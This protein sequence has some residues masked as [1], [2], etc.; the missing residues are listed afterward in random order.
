MPARIIA[1][2]ELTGRCWLRL[3]TNVVGSTDCPCSFGTS[4]VSKK[5]VVD[6]AAAAK[7]ARQ[8]KDVFMR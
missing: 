8:G 4:V 5:A 1:T 7:A 2:S 3:F 6:K